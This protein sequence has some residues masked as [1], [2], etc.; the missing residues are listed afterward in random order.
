MQQEVDILKHAASIPE[1]Q[2]EGQRQQ[3]QQ[4]GPPSDLLRQLQAAAGSL[5]GVAA[6]RDVLAGEVFRPSHVLPTMSIE[7]F[8]EVE[9]RR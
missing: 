9:Y 2:R 3:R 8:G 4:S 6:K 1:E 7:Q 5:G